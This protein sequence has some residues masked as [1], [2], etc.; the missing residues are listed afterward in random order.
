MNIT[1]TKKLLDVSKGHITTYGNLEKAVGLKN[2]QRTIEKI[3]N[4]NPY[5]L[6]FPNPRVVMSAGELVVMHMVK[7]SKQ[8]CLAIKA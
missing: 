1:F 3:M 2:G 7:M 5:L 8:K 4:N 6:W